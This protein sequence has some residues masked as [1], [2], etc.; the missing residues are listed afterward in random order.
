[1]NPPPWSWLPPLLLLLGLTGCGGSSSQPVPAAICDSDA[2]ACALAHDFGA[3]A[4]SPG[5]EVDDQCNSWTLN[6]P[7]DLYVNSVTFE[8]DGAHHHSNWFFVP[9][10][11]YAH[12]DGKWDCGKLHFTELGAALLGGVLFAQSTQARQEEQR[13]PQG[14]VVRIPAYSRVVGIVHLLNPSQRTLDTG[15]RMRLGTVAPAAVQVKLTPLRLTYSALN[16]PAGRRADFTGR[17]DLRSAWSGLRQDPF[18]MRLYYALPHYHELGRRFR[19]RELGGAMRTLY[20][21]SHGI[22]EPGGQAF[23]PP[24]DLS[25]ADGLEF[26]CGFENPRAKAVGWGIGDQE[27]CV[28]LGFMDSPLGYD[29]EV[30]KGAVTGEEAGAVQN[31]GPCG[32]SAFNFA[33]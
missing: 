14:V 19:L 18:R 31:S 3:T 33:S 17:C 27:M 4:L 9:E 26:S 7:S 25:S 28:M 22:G 29:A 21:Q 32:V 12:P 13:F 8:N 20:D 23:D 6:N 24:W 16:I 10:N 15:L 2:E 5:S 1:M 30:G 11:T